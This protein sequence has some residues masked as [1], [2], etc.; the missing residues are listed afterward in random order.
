MLKI[1]ENNGP[2]EV[3]IWADPL[4]TYYGGVLMEAQC[5]S[6]QIPNHAVTLVGYG[7]DENGVPYWKIKNSWGSNWGESGYFRL[8]R[9]ANTCNIQYYA[10]YVSS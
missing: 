10:I 6:T 4:Q 7:T 9:N 8:E 5:D 3:A 2:I 1:L